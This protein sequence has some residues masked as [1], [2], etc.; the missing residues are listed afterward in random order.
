MYWSDA[1]LDLLESAKGGLSFKVINT[2][3]GGGGVNLTLERL[4]E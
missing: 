4:K 3:E 2:F 1:K